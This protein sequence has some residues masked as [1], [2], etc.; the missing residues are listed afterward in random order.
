LEKM[1]SSTKALSSPGNYG[2]SIIFVMCLALLAAEISFNSRTV[3]FD[4]GL[5]AA[6]DTLSGH[7]DPREWQNRILFPLWLE[8][9][10]WLG[11]GLL[12]VGRTWRVARFGAATIAYLGTYFVLIR[13]TRDLRASLVGVVLVTYA[14]LWT[15]GSAGWELGEDFFDI[16]F[17]S[18]FVLLAVQ[19]NYFLMFLVVVIAAANRESAM[20]GGIVWICVAAARERLAPGAIKDYLFG[21]CCIAASAIGV[22]VLRTTL[23]PGV[24]H[25]SQGLGI[26]SVIEHWQWLIMPFGSVPMI[27]AAVFPLF[28]IA[29]QVR[30]PFPRDAI[31]LFWAT[32]ICGIITGTFGV[33]EENRIWLPCVVFAVCA[34]SMGLANSGQLGRAYLPPEAAN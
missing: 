15:A 14:Y 27:A 8:S 33:L 3:S 28:W 16:L 11:H 1:P 23:A 20:F 32:L 31:G 12:D 29:R 13:L 4:R 30:E 19:R 5:T 7:A 10:R 2:S 34:I 22:Y 6:I 21:I 9:I 18:L 24:P 25:L 17:S 26:I